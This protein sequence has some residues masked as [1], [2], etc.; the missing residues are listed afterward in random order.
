MNYL[1]RRERNILKI[2]KFGSEINI[3]QVKQIIY[4][5]LFCGN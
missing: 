2:K 3:L 5:I 1:K 4:R